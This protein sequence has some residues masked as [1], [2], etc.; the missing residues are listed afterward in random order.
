MTI[1]LGVIMDPIA[2]INVGH[3]S[4]F[5]M[6][7]AAQQRGWSIFYLEQTDLFVRDG[8]AYGRMRGLT[9]KDDAKNWY[10]FTHETTQELQVLNVILM[11]KDPPVDQEYLYTTQI[12]DLAESK[13]VLV[14][15][16]PQSLR[17]FN[18]KLFINWFPQCCPPTLITHQ[19]QQVKDFLQA[20]ADII[21]K[22]I[23]GMGGA[24]IFRLRKNDPNINV[25]IETLTNNGRH[26]LMAQKYLAEIAA[27][28]KRILMIDGQPVP[29]ALAR[30][31]AEGETRANIAAGG[32]GRG[33][34]L[35][36]RDRWLCEQIAPILRAKG[37][38]FAGIDVIGDFITEINITSPT[39]IREL[40][41]EYNLNIADQLLQCITLR[42]NKQQFAERA[43]NTV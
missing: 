40:D 15:N 26:Y 8:V 38:L 28:D 41:K 3:D 1:K 7:L 42:L 6:L 29:Y 9:V 2:Q 23:Y 11:R 10:E 34:E 5:A 32:K 24:G 18:E 31:A 19:A 43:K 4:T 36:A 14:V 16:K 13:G 21:C 25:V 35:T 33:I 39:C 17:D 27:G 22:P 20:H 30:F 37:I 12:L